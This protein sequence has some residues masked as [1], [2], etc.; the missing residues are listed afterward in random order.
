MPRELSALSMLC[1]RSKAIWGYDEAFLA[2]CRDELTLTA[3][4]LRTTTV[5]VAEKTGV[6]RGPA[7]LAVRGR[8][9]ELL[10][11]FIEPISMGRGHGIAMIRW[12]IATARRQGAQAMSVAADLGAVRFYEPMGGQVVE[13]TPSGSIPGRKLPLLDFKFSGS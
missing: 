10:R 3:A 6:P 4:E 2:A 9:A 7:Q 8:N 13:S 1:L 5:A 11:L 12:A